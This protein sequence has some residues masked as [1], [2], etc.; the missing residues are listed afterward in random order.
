M[1]VT[2]ADEMFWLQLQNVDDGLG[3]FGH[4]HQLSFYISAGHQ[5]LKD[6]PNIEIQ[7]STFT[8]RHQL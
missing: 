6:V 8:N 3:H 1:L 5:H 7:S 4:Q 2:Y